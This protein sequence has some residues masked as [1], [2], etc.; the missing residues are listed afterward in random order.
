M[1]LSIK[2]IVLCIGYKADK[3][4]NHCKNR[5]PDLDFVFVENK[6]YCST[7]NM[8]SLYLAKDYMNDDIL[9]MNADIIFDPE[10]LSGLIAEK[11]SSVA[12][13]KDMYLEESMKIIVQDNIIKGI[14]KDFLPE[15]SYGCSIDIYKILKEDIGLIK[16]EMYN[17]IMVHNNCNLWT[18]SMLNNLFKTGNLKAV[19]YNIKRRSWI[20]ID[21]Y[22]DLEKAE[23]L[24]NEKLNTLKDKKVFFIDIDGTLKLGDK[25]I[26]GAETFITKLKEKNKMFFL[27]TN[28]SSK[29]PVEHADKLKNV[30]LVIDSSNILVSIQPA[31]EYLNNNRINN[32]YYIANST[33]SK[34]IEEHGFIYNS[35][36]PQ[37]ILL[38]YDDEITYEK[39]K[40]LVVLV[41]RGIP[42]FATHIDI[43]CPTNHGDLPDIGTFI[44][45]VEMSTGILPSKTFG[46][47]N[48]SFIVEILKKNNLDEK[49]AVIIGD[50]LYTDIKLTE[51]SDITSVLVLSG[52]TSRGDYEKSDIRADIV[53]SRL[54]SI[55]NFI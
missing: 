12:V 4:V 29:T 15:E 25:V 50:R 26:K 48:K 3:I 5:Y 9:L 27:M 14:S 8:Y 36:D 35:D 31:L 1:T 10:I 38:T 51:D 30:G 52:E 2:E 45:I 18:E 19:P 53:I 49:D 37:A 43:V 11:T 20:E 6:E 54:S 17:L 21:D 7:N 55:N 33:V 16:Q 47:P 39:L 22:K 46:K 23:I 28:N 32:I 41:R 24:F 34:Y 13:A 40:K 42:Y 44:K